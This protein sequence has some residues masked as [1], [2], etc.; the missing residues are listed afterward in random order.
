MVFWSCIGRSYKLT[1]EFVSPWH[2]NCSKYEFEAMLVNCKKCIAGNYGRW[3]FNSFL[4][5]FGICEAIRQQGC[6]LIYGDW[7][8][9]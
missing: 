6:T 4:Y 7:F 9:V 5:E 8:G 2:K 1:A 3:V